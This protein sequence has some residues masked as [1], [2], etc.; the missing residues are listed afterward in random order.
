MTVH[1]SN[2]PKYTGSSGNKPNQAAAREGSSRAEAEW[3][4]RMSE[5]AASG[6][7][8]ARETLER[9]A[10]QPPNEDELLAM[11]EHPDAYSPEF[12]ERWKE[13]L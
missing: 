8:I 3:L 4:Y 12:L 13:L 10:N 5:R 11:R 9:I 1:G 2:M 6:D 7:K